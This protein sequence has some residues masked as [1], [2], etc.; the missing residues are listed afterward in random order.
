MLYRELSEAELAAI[1]DE[2]HCP[3]CRSEEF[4]EGPHALIAVNW[5][6]A[7]PK[8]LAGFNLSPPRLRVG[9]LIRESYISVGDAASTLDQMSR[10]P[11]SSLR[12]LFKRRTTLRAWFDMLKS[13]R[14]G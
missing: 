13:S 6:C 9:Q 2:C 10:T 7:N 14:W 8:C 11:E 4:F 5:Y 3:F 12:S 1:Y